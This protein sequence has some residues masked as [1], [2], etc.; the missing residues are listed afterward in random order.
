MTKVPT[1]DFKKP[2]HLWLYG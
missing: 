2:H 1:I